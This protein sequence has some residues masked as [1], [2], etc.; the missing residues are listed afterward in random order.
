MAI[1]RIINSA[2]STSTAPR[3]RLLEA[4]LR[5]RGWHWD[6]A[7]WIFRTIDLQS[8]A[9]ALR[10]P[11]NL[12]EEDRPGVASRPRDRFAAVVPLNQGTALHGVGIEILLEVNN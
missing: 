1:R 3:R 12:T 5:T 11:D 10:Q 6:D 4:A 7:E 9:V 2:I 8:V